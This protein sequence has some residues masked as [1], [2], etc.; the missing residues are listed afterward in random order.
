[1]LK[2][3]VFFIILYFIF[4]NNV[5]EGFM[6]YDQKR[7]YFMCKYSGNPY[8]PDCYNFFNEIKQIKNYII[9][10]PVGFVYK[11]G[12]RRPLSAWHDRYSRKYYYYVIDYH[13]RSP[14]RSNIIM[15]TIDNNGRELNDDDIISVPS[16]GQMKIRLYDVSINNPMYGRNFYGQYGT[17]KIIGY[18][19]SKS[20]NDFYKLYEREYPRNN[21]RYKIELYKGFFLDAKNQI[22]NGRKEDRYRFRNKLYDGDKLKIDT[23]NKQFV[24]HRYQ[25]DDIFY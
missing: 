7:R 15:H 16:R 5:N 17:W 2:Y 8:S 22:K 20:K 11:K 1:M 3:F 25:Y 19:T 18:V 4:K 21:F 10:N 13:G 12:I 24:V 23:M 9:N 14:R 6:N